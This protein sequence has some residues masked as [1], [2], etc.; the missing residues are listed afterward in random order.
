MSDVWDDLDSKGRRNILHQLHGYIRELQAL[1]MDRP[2]P[3]DGGISEGSFFT[4]YG[5]SPFKSQ[6]GRG[7]WF[8]DR[9]LVYCDF[10]HA[11]Q[12]PQGYFASQFDE[13]DM[14]YLGIHPR[15]L[16]LH[17]QDKL[18]LLDWAFSGAYLPFFETANLIWRDP[19]DF[20]AGFLELIGSNIHL[21]EIPQLLAISF[22]LTTGAYC[23]SRVR[24]NETS[25]FSGMFP[26]PEIYIFSQVGNYRQLYLKESSSL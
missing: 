2:D 15:N 25:K 9:L 24:A 10:C 6:K 22:A 14:R 12:V 3:I 11:T 19:G 20:A 18:W 26:L 8:N 23:Q 16:I 1:K 13:L 4:D 5:A 7:E 21:E 17:D